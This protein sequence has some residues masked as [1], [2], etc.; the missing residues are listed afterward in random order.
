MAKTRCRHGLRHHPL[1]NVWIGIRQR[2]EVATRHEYPRYGALGITMCEGWRSDVSLFVSWALD[3]G[4]EKGLHIDRI[5]GNSGYSPENCRVV[6]AR[7]NDRNRKS[8]KLTYS[9][10]D[11]IRYLHSLGG[12]THKSLALKFNVHTSVVTLILNNKIWLPCDGEPTANLGLYASVKPDRTRHPAREI[13]CACGCGKK[14]ITPDSQNRERRYIV[15]H[16]FR[17]HKTRTKSL[18]M[19]ANK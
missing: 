13:E 12:F 19:E 9:D 11:Q 18:Q 8:N 3:N 6:T 5:N 7:Q 16:Y 14:L 2:C 4:W 10:A 1:Y 15:G 17:D